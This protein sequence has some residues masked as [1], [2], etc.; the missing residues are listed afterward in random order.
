[1][2]FLLFVFV[3]TAIDYCC[4]SL[5]ARRTDVIGYDGDF[6]QAAVVHNYVTSH[7]QAPATWAADCVNQVLSEANIRQKHFVVYS[8]VAGDAGGDATTSI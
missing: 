2:E 5:Q 8:D 4:K 3:N 6:S 1:M 7:T